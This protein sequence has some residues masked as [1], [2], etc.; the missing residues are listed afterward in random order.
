MPRA[1]SR[2]LFD[3]LRL[4]RSPHGWHE[5]AHEWRRGRAGVPALPPRPIA[6]V[7]VVCHGNICR[8][9][10]AAAYLSNRIPELEVRSSGLAA[11]A[12]WPADP[13]AV[14]VAARHGLDLSQHHSRPL[15]PA[16][17][18]EPD[19]VLVMEAAQAAAFR[20][21]APALAERVYVL[22]D[23]LTA[24]PFGIADPF[25]CSEAVF[26]RT[27]AQIVAALDQLS[28]RLKERAT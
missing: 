23:F 10:F 9:P 22:G 27:F 21:R 2:S 5:L 11:G 20:A 1:V 26:E 18:N 13:T 17:L 12:A 8:S 3:T 16:D 4:L 24:P 28:L 6:R 7:L 25:G 19:L 14:R 15:A